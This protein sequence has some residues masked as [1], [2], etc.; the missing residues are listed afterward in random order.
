LQIHPR[1]DAHGQDEQNADRNVIGNGHGPTDIAFISTYPRILILFPDI[2]AHDALLIC[3]AQAAIDKGPQRFHKPL[4][5]PLFPLRRV[6]PAQLPICPPREGSRPILPSY[7]SCFA[8][9]NVG[10]F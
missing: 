9:R 2:H 8:E 4:T 7:R 1:H 6:G 5:R 10:Q 3:A